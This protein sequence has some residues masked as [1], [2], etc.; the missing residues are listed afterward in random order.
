MHFSLQLYVYDNI[1]YEL[2]PINSDKLRMLT[3]V[4]PK[5][6][7]CDKIRDE[8]LVC[9][10]PTDCV[11]LRGGTAG[12]LLLDDDAPL[13]K[14]CREVLWTLTGAT[15]SILMVVSHDFQFHKTMFSS[16]GQFPKLKLSSDAETTPHNQSGHQF[17]IL[18]LGGERTRL[19]KVVG[20]LFS[21][22]EHTQ[23]KRIN[24]N[25]LPFLDAMIKKLLHPIRFKWKPLVQ[26]S[27]MEWPRAQCPY[28]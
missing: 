23:N 4:D 22:R 3:G 5:E 18:L 16:I 20:A 17:P 28:L 13:P 6:L 11:R 8:V 10:C 19:S 1:P 9:W 26:K 21:S 15:G 14:A 24:L 27:V 2:K 12:L 7:V 25:D